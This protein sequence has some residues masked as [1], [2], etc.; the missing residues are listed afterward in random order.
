MLEKHQV[1]VARCMFLSK[2]VR[3]FDSQ[4]FCSPLPSLHF[5][6]WTR[7]ARVNQHWMLNGIPKSPFWQKDDEHPFAKKD[8]ASI[9]GSFCFKSRLLFLDPQNLQ[10]HPTPSKNPPKVEVLGLGREARLRFLES[11]VSKIQS[12]ICH[13]KKIGKKKHLPTPRSLG[14]GSVRTDFARQSRMVPW[15]C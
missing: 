11:R 9:L 1:C 7:N 8:A 15:T 3:F 10:Q 13:S 12:Y 4:P 2:V 14:L 6:C 5:W